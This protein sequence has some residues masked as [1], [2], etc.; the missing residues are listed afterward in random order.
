MYLISRFFDLMTT[1]FFVFWMLLYLAESHD[2]AAICLSAVLICVVCM[3]GFRLF[4]FY[5]ITRHRLKQ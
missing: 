3:V 5:K 1:V 2:L 4:I